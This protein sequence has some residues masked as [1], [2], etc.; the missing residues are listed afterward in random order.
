LSLPDWLLMFLGLG[1]FSWSRHVCVRLNL[2]RSAS[3]EDLVGLWW[4]AFAGMGE[5]IIHW[6]D[7]PRLKRTLLQKRTTTFEDAFC[8]QLLAPWH[9]FGIWSDDFSSMI[10]LE[11]QLA[12]WPF[13]TCFSQ[14]FV[15]DRMRLFAQ[16]NS[17]MHMLHICIR[18]IGTCLVMLHLI[19]NF[20]GM[21][22]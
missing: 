10:W 5:L 3:T 11:M 16:S 22:A 2:L 4:C 13:F 20:L 12:W 8:D 15:W 9:C 18:D 7:W 14:A 17:S 1:P 6:H 21:A 19:N